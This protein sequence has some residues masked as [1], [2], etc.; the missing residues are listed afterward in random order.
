MI[1]Y[2]IFEDLN[3]DLL[4][5]LGKVKNDYL[6]HVFQLPEWLNSIV[7]TSRE[8]KNLKVVVIY[9]K[10]EIILVAPLC[11]YNI[12]GCKELRWISSDTIDYNNAIISKSFN[13]DVIDFKNLWKEIIDVLSKH[14][15][16][17][18]FHKIPEFIEFKRNPLINFNYKNYQKSYQLILNNFNYDVFY[19]QNNN[20][21]S[22]QTDRRKEKKLYDKND[23]KYFYNDIN[24]ENFYLVEELINEKMT[25]YKNKK[26]KTFDCKNT[27]VKYNYLIKSIDSDVKFNLSILKKD[28]RKISA[29]FGAIFKE[30]YYYLIPITYNT[31]FKKYSPGRFHIANLIN[32]AAKNNIKIIDFTAGDEIYKSDWSNNSFNMFYYIKLNNLKGLLR[33]FFL[34]LYFKL[35]K[36]LLLKKIY[37][38]I[39]YGF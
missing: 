6:L 34:I 25:H 2:K 22:K 21:K 35:R 17:I 38:L 30:I 3:N 18:F 1:H 19:N 12:H 32:W 14:C 7:N 36:N 28:G 29:I 9:E 23:V 37:Q 27:L 39:K 26:E 15:D 16:L 5:E 20:S 24:L 11:I 8:Y 33:F 13:F 10:K 4:K 31:Q